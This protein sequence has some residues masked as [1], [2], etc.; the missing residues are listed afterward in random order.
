[1]RLRWPAR[2]FIGL[3]LLG[4]LSLAPATWAQYEYDPSAADEQAP[5]IRYFGTVK[6]DR[7]SLIPGAIVALDSDRFNL[8]FLTDELGRFHANLPLGTTPEKVTPGCSKPGYS[9]IRVTKRP[10]PA[11]VKPTVQIVCILRVATTKK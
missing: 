9:L 10:G 7:G 1:M 6:D 4:L 8:V 2:T 11:G 5:G 3:S